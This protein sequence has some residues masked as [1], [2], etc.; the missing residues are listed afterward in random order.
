MIQTQSL[1]ADIARLVLEQS[2]LET[3]LSRAA[4]LLRDVIPFERLH[5]LRLDRSDSVTL[6][7]VRASGEVDVTGHLI[8]DSATASTEALKALNVRD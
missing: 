4:I 7:V 5:V 1:L 2:L 6:Y 8:G 3:T